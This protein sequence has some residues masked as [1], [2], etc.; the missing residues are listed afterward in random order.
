MV[1]TYPTQ[2][3][4]VFGM[5]N[6]STLRRDNAHNTGNLDSRAFQG[7]FP[8]PESRSGMGH[9]RQQASQTKVSKVAAKGPFSGLL[10]I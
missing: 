6:P 8:A 2:Y 7:P 9:L 10:H 5:A 1:Y 4:S 3:S